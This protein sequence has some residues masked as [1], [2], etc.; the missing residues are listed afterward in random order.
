MLPPGIAC[1]GAVA[2]RRTCASPGAEQ[3]PMPSTT[4]PHA[5]CCRLAP[6]NCRASGFEIVQRQRNG[7]GPTRWAE[8]SPRPVVVCG[9]GRAFSTTLTAPG[10]W[11]HTRHKEDRGGLFG[12]SEMADPF[13]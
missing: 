11:L 8:R 12:R 7:P 2:T 4:R 1:N 3:S 6:T 5:Q 13:L 9:H 10:T